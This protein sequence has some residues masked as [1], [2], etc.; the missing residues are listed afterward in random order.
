LPSATGC[1]GSYRRLRTNSLRAA[2][3]NA[4]QKKRGKGGA[5]QAQGTIVRRCKGA[6]QSKAGCSTLRN[7]NM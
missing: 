5:G 6:K 3:A 7:R 4:L 2:G 1:T